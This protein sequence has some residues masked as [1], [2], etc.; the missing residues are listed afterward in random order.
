MG[1]DYMTG[2]DG[3]KR[4]SQDHKNTQFFISSGNCTD[5]DMK[6]YKGEGANGCFTKPYP[7]DMKGA[8]GL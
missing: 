4:V 3:I 6:Y 2:T 5:D 8:L 1:S 7:E